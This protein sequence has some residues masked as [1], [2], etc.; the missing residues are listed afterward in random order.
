MG[1]LSLEPI[2]LDYGLNV[3]FW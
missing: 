3:W 1:L 2:D